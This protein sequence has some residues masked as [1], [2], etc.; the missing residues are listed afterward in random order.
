MGSII[1]T[2]DTL[3]ITP[4][5]GFP[6]ELVLERHLQEPYELKDF[7][8]KIFEFRDK[9]G[10]RVYHAPP[11]RNFLVENRDGKWIYWGLAHILETTLDLVNKKTSGKFKVIKLYTPEEMKEVFSLTDGMAKTNYFA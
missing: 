9:P 6:A 5:Q 11:V 3:Q 4:K 1:E 7:E 8:N 2:N 10:L